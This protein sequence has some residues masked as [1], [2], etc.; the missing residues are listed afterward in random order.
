MISK[1]QQKYIQSLHNKKNR[2]EY[3]QFIV[4][5]EKGLLELM[6]SDF[7]ILELYCSEYFA[8]KNKPKVR[9]TL[10]S[11][12]ELESI[13]TLKTNTA[14]V[15]IVKQKRNTPPENFSEVTLFL[16]NINDPGNLGTIIRLADWY[17]VK[18]IVCSLNTVEFYN[19]KV[20]ISTMGSFTR[21]HIYY[22]DLTKYLSDFKFPVYG[23]DLE[24]N[25]V[26][27]HSFEDKIGLVIGSES[28]G[29]SKEV[30]SL[31]TQRITIPRMNL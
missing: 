28:H 13:S 1:Q 14:G 27:F 19:P 17:G 30:E 18:N 6:G 7:E 26:H 11:I 20:I 21:T 2:S 24:G 9:F 22:S 10:C 16:D 4:E 12:S 5:G 15:A 23:G 3:G 8:E 29:I 31:L 25:N